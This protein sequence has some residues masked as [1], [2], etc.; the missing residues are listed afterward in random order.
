M[1]CSGWQ[2]E[3]V[4][5]PHLKNML[6]LEQWKGLRKL[7]K[8]VTLVP[9]LAGPGARGGGPATSVGFFSMFLGSK[10]LSAVARE[11]R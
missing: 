1:G 6:L 11:T 8:G 4:S 9:V 3:E 5:L 7:R 2:S 10:S